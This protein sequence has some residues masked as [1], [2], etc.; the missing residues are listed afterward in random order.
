MTTLRANLIAVLQLDSQVQHS[1]QSSTLQ[2]LIQATLN[3]RLVDS[4]RA[5]KTDNRISGEQEI[6]KPKNYGN[7]LEGSV[8]L[9]SALVKSLNLPTIGLV[10]DLVHSV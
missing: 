1:S 10:E 9:R 7:K 5:Y 2:H 6:W 8:T 4:P 3:S